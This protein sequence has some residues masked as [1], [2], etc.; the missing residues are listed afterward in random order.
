[1]RKYLIAAMAVVSRL[2]MR[3]QRRNGVRR[4][5]E[6]GDVRRELQ[7]EQPRRH[8]STNAGCSSKPRRC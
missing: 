4:V 6:H 1:M 2:G 3:C 5:A 7:P 8:A